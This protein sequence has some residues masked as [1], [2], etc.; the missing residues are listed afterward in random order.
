P[1]SPHVAIQL[2]PDGAAPRRAARRVRLTSPTGL[3]QLARR[4]GTLEFCPGATA[5]RKFTDD[6]ISLETARFG[7]RLI[8]KGDFQ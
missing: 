2:A 6:M 4:R 8:Y 5:G 1:G 3:R 7:G